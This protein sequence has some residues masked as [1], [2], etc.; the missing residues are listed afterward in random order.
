MKKERERNERI[1]SFFFLLSKLGVVKMLYVRGYKSS[2]LKNCCMFDEI[3]LICC[4]YGNKPIRY[5]VI[6][7][8]T[9]LLNSQIIN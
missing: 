7:I 8:V 4:Q 6:L 1:F 2:M 9:L 3:I 5:P